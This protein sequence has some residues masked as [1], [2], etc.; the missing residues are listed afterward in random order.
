MDKV[1]GIKPGPDHYACTIDLL[2]CSGKMREAKELLNEMVVEPDAIVWKALL[3]G[4]YT[5]NNPKEGDSSEQRLL[6]SIAINQP[7]QTGELKQDVLDLRRIVLEAL[8]LKSAMVASLTGYTFWLL[9]RA[10]TSAI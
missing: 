3:A 10:R 1:Y 5:H 6:S 4:M 8:I 2:G 9:R 7:L